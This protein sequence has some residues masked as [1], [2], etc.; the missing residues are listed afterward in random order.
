M[1]TMERARNRMR[2]KISNVLMALTIVGCVL[3]VISGRQAAERGE[4][5]QKANLEW[6]RKYNEDNKTKET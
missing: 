5:V 4:S 3:M 6:H 1:D 2:I